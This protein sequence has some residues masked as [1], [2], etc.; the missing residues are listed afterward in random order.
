MG[1]A[2]AFAVFGLATRFAGAL[3]VFA[4]SAVTAAAPLLAVFASEDFFGA[5]VV[6]GA[7]A[8]LDERVESGVRR[9]AM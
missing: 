7:A 6:E 8:G 2:A 9:L 5:L 4:T 3:A 1:A